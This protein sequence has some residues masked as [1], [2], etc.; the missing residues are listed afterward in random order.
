ML[1]ILTPGTRSAAM[2]RGGLSKRRVLCRLRNLAH[3][4]A[5]EL[6]KAMR[7]FAISSKFPSVFGTKS[8]GPEAGPLS[9]ID[10]CSTHVAVLE[11]QT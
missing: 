5:L 3:L 2:M 7:S 8:L 10:P 4:R 11:P 9:A 6:D 1:G